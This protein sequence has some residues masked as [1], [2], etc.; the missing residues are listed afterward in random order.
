MLGCCCTYK[1]GYRTLVSAALKS[2]A[3]CTLI[4][5]KKKKMFYQSPRGFRMLEVA[6]FGESRAAALWRG[7]FSALLLRRI[8]CTTRVN[9]LQPTT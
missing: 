9:V 8:N 5:E 1:L 4:L 2:L 3:C 7:P 6:N